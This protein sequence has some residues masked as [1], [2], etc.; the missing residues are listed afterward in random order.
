TSKEASRRKETS[1]QFLRA[2]VD[3]GNVEGMVCL[4]QLV[5]TNNNSP[6][7]QVDQ[8]KTDHGKGA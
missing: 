2:V 6:T 3:C 4:V 8:R 5:P 1:V 7:T